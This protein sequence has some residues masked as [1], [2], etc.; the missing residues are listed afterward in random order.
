[1]ARFCTSE[2]YNLFIFQASIS[3]TLRFVEIYSSAETF[4]SS[5]SNINDSNLIVTEQ[6]QRYK[7]YLIL[8]VEVF[9]NRNLLP[10]H[11]PIV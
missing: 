8:E 6:T 2:L 7:G 10:E 11:L 5:Q 3:T 1:M 4:Q 9:S